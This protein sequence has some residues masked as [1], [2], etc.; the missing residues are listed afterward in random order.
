M[1]QHN[2]RLFGYERVYPPVHKETPFLIQ[3][4][5]MTVSI[6]K[7]YMLHLPTENTE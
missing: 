4:S 5:E 3:W 7:I 1:S 2:I 6:F